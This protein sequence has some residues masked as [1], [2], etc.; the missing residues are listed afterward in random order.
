V[1]QR[2]LIPARCRFCKR[3]I[4]VRAD[5]KTMTAAT[6][7]GPDRCKG[8]TNMPNLI[9]GKAIPDVGVVL[10]IDEERA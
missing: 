9:N 1:K 2:M 6:R 3:F 5:D 8:C 7:E 10:T 4:I